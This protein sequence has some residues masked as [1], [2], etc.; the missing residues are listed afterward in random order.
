MLERY[1][2]LRSEDCPD[3]RTVYGLPRV[4]PE[5][6][7]DTREPEGSRP[8]V[9]RFGATILWMGLVI[10]ALIAGLL[11]VS[12]PRLA[13]TVGSFRAKTRQDTVINLNGAKISTESNRCEW[14]PVL[15]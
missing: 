1:L 15:W 13:K 6:G 7:A 3:Y 14:S 10:G 5:P 2:K 12:E 9:S 11:A 4:T 8:A